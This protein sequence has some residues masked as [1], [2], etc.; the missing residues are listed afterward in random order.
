[1][2]MSKTGV[3]SRF[4][5]MQTLQLDVLDLYKRRFEEAV[6]Y[7][8]L[9]VPA[10]LPRLRT[11]FENWTRH[12]A[13][14]NGFGCFYI[15]CA[16]EYDDQPGLIRDTLRQLILL[17]REV[18]EQCI[19]QAVELGQLQA[20][21]DTGQLAHEIY[22]LALVLH[23]DIRLLEDHKCIKRTQTAFD[24]L[25]SHCKSEDYREP[26]RHVRVCHARRITKWHASV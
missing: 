16:A 8:I 12:I 2:Q 14:N 19:Q 1:M 11:M 6:F 17:W 13:S 23:H 9:Q 26:A 10:G 18:L 5:S 7:Q 21:T 22:G 15:S 24:R 3:F 20:T 25:I 4:G